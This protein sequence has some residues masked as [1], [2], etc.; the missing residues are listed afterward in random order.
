MTKAAVPISVDD[1]ADVWVVPAPDFRDAP[2]P[3]EGP[4]SPKEKTGRSSIWTVAG[5]G[6]SQV[7]R[8]GS[9]IILARLLTTSDFALAGIVG[10]VM[11][12]LQQFSD[13]GLGPAII[14]SRRGDDPRFLN[15][16]WTMAAVRG[17]FLW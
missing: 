12:M 3:A 16:A 7:I 15:T 11:G 10:I 14:Q 2:A 1:V 9:S 8:F 5:F 4:Q 13:I 17:V 6:S